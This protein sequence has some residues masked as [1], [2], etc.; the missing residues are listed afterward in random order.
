MTETPTAAP[1]PAA[2]ASP[3]P[4]L[5]DAVEAAGAPAPAETSASPAPAEVP[6]ADW[7]GKVESLPPGAQSLIR[8]LRGESAERRTKL[9]T[10]EE[11]Q[12]AL[13]RAV[14]KAAGLDVPDEG[15][16][17]PPAAE[18]TA[19]IEAAQQTAREARVELGVYRLATDPAAPVKADVGALLDSRTFQRAVSALDPD[20]DDFAEKVQTAIASAVTA[21]PKLAQVQAAGA[22]G[23]DF[24]GGTGGERTSRTPRSLDEAVAG[25]YGTG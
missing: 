11:Q 10:A 9:T 6:P 23:A 2:P 19:T 7:D 18:V 4:T 1:A 20:A 12:T 25:A 17:A 21:N 5:A 16:E 22:S 3:A 24:T 8:Q 15:G 13:L 14:A